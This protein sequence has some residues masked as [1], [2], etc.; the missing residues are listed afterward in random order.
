VV[1]VV[2]VPAVGGEA[3]DPL[4]VIDHFADVLDDEGASAKRVD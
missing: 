2:G 4:V 1:A 3:V